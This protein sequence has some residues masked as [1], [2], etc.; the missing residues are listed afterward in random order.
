ME[1]KQAVTQMTQYDKSDEAVTAIFDAVEP[2]C[3]TSTDGGDGETP[4]WDWL[5]ATG[6]YTGSETPDSIA[7]EWDSLFQ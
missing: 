4:L 2:L 6:G 1:F 5:A 3:K 7:V